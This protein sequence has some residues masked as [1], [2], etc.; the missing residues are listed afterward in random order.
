MANLTIP[1]E[2]T[3]TSF[4]VTA[5]DAGPFP[6]TFSIFA[7]ADLRVSIDGAELGQEDFTFSGTLIDSGYDGGS[8]TLNEEV[9][10]CEV[11]IWRDIAPVRTTDFAPAA[12]IPVKDIDAELDRLT[13]IIQD[14]KRDQARSLLMPFGDLIGTL[15][16]STDRADTVLTFDDSGEIALLAVDEFIGADG[17]AGDDGADGAAGADGLQIRSG[18]GAPGSG[19]GA[20]GEFYIDT[21]ATALYGPKTAGAWGSGTSL[22]GPAGAGSGDMLKTEN[23]SGLANYTTARSNLGLVIGTNVQAY[24]AGLLSIAGLTTAADRMIYTTAL[25]TYAVATLT[26]FARTILDDADAA[27]V[28]TTLGLTIG[29]NVQAYDAGL[30]SIAGLTTAA[31]KMVYTTGSD[32]Y[33]VTDLSAFARTL[34]DDADAAA[35][36]TTLGVS[37]GQ[38]ITAMGI[39]SIS[40]GTLTALYDN[41]LT[42][43]R[44]STGTYTI[45]LDTAAASANTWAFWVQCGYDASNVRTA[46]EKPTRTATTGYF[47]VRPGSGGAVSDPDRM[48]VFAVV[49]S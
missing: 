23:L 2:D 12:N 11:L 14:A 26:S 25:D 42:V 18:S 6:F 40:G 19:V 10:D 29:T 4:S 17:P 9:E 36:R 31:D 24:D 5:A 41:G 21:A 16:G 35:A 1:D 45:T 47:D 27:A 33:A 43:A 22:I 3:Y 7:K 37:A 38:A 39:Y 8:I 20:N 32:T 46:T 49:T 15:A 34:L 28:K 48:F 44:T 30:T 13:A